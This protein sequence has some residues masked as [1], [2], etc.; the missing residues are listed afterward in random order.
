ME[1]NSHYHHNS[2]ITYFLFN[3]KYFFFFLIL[4]PD[5]F[6]F[7]LYSLFEALVLLLNSEYTC[8]NCIYK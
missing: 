4:T 2:E 5:S 6:S 8:K 3:L 1:L 7:A